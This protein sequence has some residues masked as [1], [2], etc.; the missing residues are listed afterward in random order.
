VDDVDSCLVVTPMV[1]LT[2]F[3]EDV[4]GD[5]QVLVSD[6]CDYMYAWF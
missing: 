5:R 3:I 1:A 6:I 2:L 4:F